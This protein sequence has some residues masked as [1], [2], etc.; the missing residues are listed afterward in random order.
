MAEP[1]RAIPG[2][3]SPPAMR[4]MT[5][6]DIGRRLLPIFAQ[7]Q[8]GSVLADFARFIGDSYPPHEREE[9]ALLNMEGLAWLVRQ[10]LLVQD[11]SQMLSGSIWYK[12]S[13]EGR[14]YVTASR[15]PAAL[16]LDAPVRALLHPRILLV[17]TPLY[18]R[19]PDSYP[20]AIASAFTHVETATREHIRDR[21]GTPTQNV[22]AVLYSEAFAPPNGVLLPPSCDRGEADGLRAFFAGAFGGLRSPHAHGFLRVEEDEAVARLLIIASEQI[23]IL[24]R[25]AEMSRA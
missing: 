20:E 21:R 1:M 10:G 5:P 17:A 13:R 24:E 3:P 8:R 16:V 9:M 25:L 22:G 23:F 2:R 12:L 7:N 15:A 11:P 19:G 4:L 18:E 6:S 14:S